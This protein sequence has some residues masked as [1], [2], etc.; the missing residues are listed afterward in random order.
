MD[1][2]Y[3]NERTRTREQIARSHSTMLMYIRCF[4]SMI[5]LWLFEE[6]H[7]HTP[8]SLHTNNQSDKK[9]TNFMVDSYFFYIT[10]EHFFSVCFSL[11]F[12]PNRTGMA[13]GA[14][15]MDAERV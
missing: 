4:W 9:G 7:M 11:F 5:N 8:S 1:M 2:K 15:S 14:A 12:I 10:I 13:T 6:A 3:E